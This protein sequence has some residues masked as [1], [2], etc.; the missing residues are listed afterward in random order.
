[1]KLW[2]QLIFKKCPFKLTN[3]QITKQNSVV[4]KSS[5]SKHQ[6]YW[7]V[8]ILVK[9]VGHKDSD[10]F[11]LISLEDASRWQSNPLDD[12]LKLLYQTNG[13]RQWFLHLDTKSNQ[14][15]KQNLRFKTFPAPKRCGT[16]LYLDKCCLNLA[17]GA[18]PLPWKMTNWF[19]CQFFEYKIVKVIRMGVT[20]AIQ[21]YCSWSKG[22][23]DSSRP[24]STN[25]L[26]IRSRICI[27]LALNLYC[28]IMGNWGRT[29]NANDPKCL[30]T[31][32]K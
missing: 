31:V 19:V 13:L 14:S 8:S 25:H 30:G 10:C 12:N 4:N 32:V 7:D 15:Y 24:K 27:F 17:P 23:L 5:F 18:L 26:R 1:M 29:F 21:T 20:D 2:S 6:G 16:N 3:T 9:V 11:V 22:R 28:D